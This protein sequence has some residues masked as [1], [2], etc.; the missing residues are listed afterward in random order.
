MPTTQNLRNKIDKNL[1][2]IDGVMDASHS[3]LASI[4]KALA[5]FNEEYTSDVC[6]AYS[7]QFIKAIAEVE[8]ILK[9]SE[10]AY[11]DYMKIRDT[12]FDPVPPI[13]EEL[14]F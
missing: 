7:E 9:I 13:W 3:L 4:H 10:L 11:S 2:A 5:V 14:K 12:L 1:H 8:N 6:S